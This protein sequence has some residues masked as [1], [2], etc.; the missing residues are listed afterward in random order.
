MVSVPG[1][2]ESVMSVSGVG[3]G[4]DVVVSGV[5][6]SGDVVLAMSVPVMWC[7]CPVVWYR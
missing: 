1:D 7:R 4:V 2:V 3:V 6:A 5:L